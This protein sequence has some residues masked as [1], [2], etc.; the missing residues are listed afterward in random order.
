MDK[1]IVSI[2]QILLNSTLITTN[3][4]QEEFN[5]SKRQITYRINK[6]NDML[7]VKNVPLICLRADK[8]IIVRKETKKAIKEILEK[9]YSKNTY[10]ILYTY[11]ASNDLLNV[12]IEGCR[13]I[14]KIK[15][16]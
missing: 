2:L 13:N 4:L 1:E 3:G 8:D 11:E 15:E 12:D 16:K 6:I 5:S 14:K 7:K 10:C 9:N